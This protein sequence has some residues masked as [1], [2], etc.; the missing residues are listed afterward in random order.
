MCRHLQ[1]HLLLPILVPTHK[2]L[3]GYQ[4]VKKALAAG[5]LGMLLR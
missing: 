4:D 2:S 5:T 1:R 3:H